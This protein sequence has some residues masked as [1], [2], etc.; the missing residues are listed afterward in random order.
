MTHVIVQGPIDVALVV[1]HTHTH[2][3]TQNCRC[4]LDRLVS[5]IAEY[6][7]PCQNTNKNNLIVNF[8]EANIR[9]YTR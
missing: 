7:K 3:H 8:V 6:M 2:T 4:L 5:M 9:H 1:E